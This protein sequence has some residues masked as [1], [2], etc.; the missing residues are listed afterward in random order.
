MDFYI[1]AKRAVIELDGKQHRINEISE[2]DITR[3]NY[4]ESLGITVLRFDNSYINNKFNDVC[5][6]ILNRLNIE[7]S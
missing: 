4:L 5:R 2:N 6:S 3:Q 7:L 1:P